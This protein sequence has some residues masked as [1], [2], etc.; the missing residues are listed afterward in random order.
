MPARPE[1]AFPAPSFLGDP[2]EM[3]LDFRVAGLLWPG[4][5]SG[6]LFRDKAN[7]APGRHAKGAGAGL[8][9]NLRWG[10]WEPEGRMNCPCRGHCRWPLGG[11]LPGSQTPATGSG[12]GPEEGHRAFQ[13]IGVSGTSPP[14]MMGPIGEIHPGRAWS[15]AKARP[16]RQEPRAPGEIQWTLRATAL[17]MSRRYGPTMLARP[18][19]A[20]GSSRRAS[21]GG[22]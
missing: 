1:F 11:R 7:P 18:R 8:L 13:V 2:V 6:Q 9:G 21:S 16:P 12:S 14:G 19:R 22:P 20:S 4:D 10:G 5:I 3:F 17:L 15:T